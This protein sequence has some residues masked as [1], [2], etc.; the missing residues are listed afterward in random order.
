MRFLRASGS[1]GMSAAY[2]LYARFLTA[3]TH[4]FSETSQLKGPGQS[5]A[6]RILFLVE[7]FGSSFMI[8]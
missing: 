1:T 6:K 8:R 7:A 2:S 5:V 4:S 3:Y